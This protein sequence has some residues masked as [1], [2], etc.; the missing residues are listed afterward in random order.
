MSRAPVPLQAMSPRLAIHR[1]ERRFCRHQPSFVD[2]R[3]PCA[4]R[5]V[6]LDWYLGR[7]WG[8]DA[9]VDDRTIGVAEVAHLITGGDPEQWLVD[10]I[11][12]LSR[13][14][15]VEP[16]TAEESHEYDAIRADVHNAARCLTEWLPLFLAAPIKFRA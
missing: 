11:T 6:L 3:L 9:R 4:D 7:G 15:D 10:G 1:A 13:L 14:V 16:R 2:I 12:H 5:D 8:V